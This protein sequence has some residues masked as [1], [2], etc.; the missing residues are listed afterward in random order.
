MANATAKEHAARVLLHRW[1][2]FVE[3]DDNDV[4]TTLELMAPDIVLRTTYG[5]GKGHAAILAMLASLP[6]GH[7]NSHALQA[8]A[9]APEAGGGTGVS[10]DILHQ[11]RTPQGVQNRMPLHY[12]VRL[13]ERPGAL[14]QFKRI[15]IRATGPNTPDPGP[16]MDQF[17]GH[18]ARSAFYQWLFLHDQNEADAT[19]FSQLLDGKGFELQLPEGTVA[20]TAA[21][22]A[23][24]ASRC[25]GL[26]DSQHRVEALAVDPQRDGN[27]ALRAA[28]SWKG[29]DASGR[30][31]AGA[32]QHIWNLRESKERYPRIERIKVEVTRPFQA[33]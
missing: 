15:D 13:G 33:V 21:F 22:A 20:D 26:K 31:M 10:L 4:P 18:R 24:W 17:A 30:A 25:P 16:F 28:L 27:Y 1:F 3:R 2:A 6:R 7:S 8:F 32:S 23:H 9:V 14:P 5:E 29:T 19:P 11:H 12:E